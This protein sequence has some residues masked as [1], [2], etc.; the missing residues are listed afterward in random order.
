MDSDYLYPHCTNEKTEAQKKLLKATQLERTEIQVILCSKPLS[1]ALAE[2]L[3]W[4]SEFT[5]ITGHVS[6]HTHVSLV[7]PKPWAILAS[8]I[9]YWACRP[10]P[11]PAPPSWELDP[12]LSLLGL[13]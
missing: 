10:G 3:A 4:F 9:A 11:S 6:I 7:F 1:C 5:V 8:Q 2:L 13:P 12:C